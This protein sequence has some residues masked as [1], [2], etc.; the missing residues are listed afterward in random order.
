MNT[1]LTSVAIY[2][3]LLIL[4]R[5]AGKRA[6]SEITTFDFV[7]LLIISEATQQAI[8][9]SD[10]SLTSAAIAI[11]TLV[12]CDISLSLIKLR[13]RKVDILLEGLPLVLVRDGHPL[14][15]RMRMSR[16]EREDILLAARGAHGIASMDEI[17]YAV[18]EPHGGISIIPRS[19]E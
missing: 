16:V 13:S 8:V 18:L 3:F 11:V 17:R 2:F 10:S 5:I 4:F 1:V 12:L 9:G 15:E 7:L 6:V 14:E 19:R